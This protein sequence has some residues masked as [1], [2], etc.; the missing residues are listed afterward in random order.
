LLLSAFSPDGGGRVALLARL[1]DETRRGL[2]TAGLAATPV[3]PPTRAAVLRAIA[4]VQRALAA[5]P[6]GAPPPT[7]YFVY[8]GHGLDG[9]ILL[10]PEAGA[11]AALTGHELRAAIAE[12]GRAV[13][14]LRAYVFIDACRS[15]S[16]FTER[17]AAGAEAIGPDL[18][19]DVAA[20]EGRADAVSIGVLTAASSGHT[21][22]EVR[23]L[24]AGYFS[25][26]LASGLA[27]A[28]DADGDEL[29]T[30]AEL[31]A[32]VAYNTERL[33]AQRP[34][35][36]PPAGDLAAPVVD[37]RRAPAR[38]ELSA[39][40][41]GRY[42]VEATGGR[43]I[44]AEAVKGDNRPLRL[45]LPVGRYRVLR[46]SPREPARAAD[47]SLV[48]HAR[49]DAAQ[50]T[51]TDAAASAP[52][53]SRGDDA[54]GDALDPGAPAFGSPF[55]TEAV[56]TLATA[57]AAGREPASTPGGATHRIGIAATFGSAPLSLPGAELGLA[58]R[59]RQRWGLLFA[60]AQ[61]AFGRSSSA[62]LSGYHLDRWSALVEIGPR[63]SF[64]RSRE[65]LELSVA[66]AA[67]GG[68][69]VRRGDGDTSGDAFAPLVGAG[70]GTALRLDARWSITLDAHATAQWVDVDQ[71]ARRTV[72]AG[73]LAGLAWGF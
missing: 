15:Q 9:R 13:P 30:F 73:L 10:E 40:P 28:A 61:A 62:E 57:Y 56:S 51:W 19:A 38:L 17:G 4:D 29:V 39:A 25:H 48:A 49:F 21:T 63:W 5:R 71:A 59:Y 60:G 26:V 8:A 7:F 32:F 33:G 11:E 22:G 23:A 12:L 52:T 35:F 36:S 67:G 54:G 68:P 55:T 64:G 1:D 14:A 58:V 41:A 50:M 46:A 45:A 18:S 66:I 72:T 16:L 27:G 53:R 37:L 6:A 20:L 69:V 65:W 44:L 42:L 47:V 31:A 3:G 70:L 34:W 24:G 2:A 43:P